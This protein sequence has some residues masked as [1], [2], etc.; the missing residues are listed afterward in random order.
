MRKE[1]RKLLS[2]V[3]EKGFMELRPYGVA[4]ID[5]LFDMTNQKLSWE[6]RQSMERIKY[7]MAQN[8]DKN[9]EKAIEECKFYTEILKMRQINIEQHANLQQLDLF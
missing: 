4:H 2:R 9:L 5:E 6:Q 1:K 8:D 3:L 7:Y